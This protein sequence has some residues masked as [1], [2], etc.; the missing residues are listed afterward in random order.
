MKIR[1]GS[2]GQNS[3][4]H[5]D[6]QPKNLFVHRVWIRCCFFV[7]FLRRALRFR[8]SGIR[9]EID[10]EYQSAGISEKQVL[11]RTRKSLPKS[12]GRHRPSE[13]PF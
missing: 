1:C 11:Q 2:L 5:I 7:F 13:F 12:V 3:V 9:W 6:D 8:G 10:L 4:A